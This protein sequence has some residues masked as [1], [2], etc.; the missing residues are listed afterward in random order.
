M[1]PRLLRRGNDTF[2]VS[3][4]QDI[5]SNEVIPFEGDLMAY[6]RAHWNLFQSA[7]GEAFELETNYFRQVESVGD[8][9][10]LDVKEIELRALE[11]CRQLYGHDCP[12]SVTVADLD[13]SFSKRFKFTFE[14]LDASN[15]IIE[16][17]CNILERMPALP[18]E[19]IDTPA[20][21]DFEYQMSSL[22]DGVQ[23]DAPLWERLHVT[24]YM[25]DIVLRTTLASVM[26]ALYFE[27]IGIDFLNIL[28]ALLEMVS[29]LAN[30]ITDARTGWRAFLVRAYVWCIWHRCQ[31][32]YFHAASVDASLQGSTDGKITR[33][34]LRSSLPSPGITLQEM[35]KRYA[36]RDKSAYMC[37]WNL[38]LLRTNPVCIGGDF[39]R[40]HRLYNAA[41]RGYSARCFASQPHPCTGES[42]RKCQRFYGMIIKDQSAHDQDCSGNCKAMSWDE[43]S[44]RGLSGGRAVSLAQTQISANMSL[45]YCNATDRTLAIS[46]VWSQ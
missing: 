8:K 21:V 26:D 7:R 15:M 22:A 13:T 2:T 16:R 37:G 34:G 40:F 46:H 44:Y 41:F 11:F 18:P 3:R 32:I 4:L 23:S 17:A 27:R 12:A 14:P 9:R 6:N 33:L 36:T 20:A 5:L 19:L 35:S 10:E 38:E 39:R 31:L 25:S 42:P 28:A 24:T 43:N 30:I 45:Q 1:D 29:Q